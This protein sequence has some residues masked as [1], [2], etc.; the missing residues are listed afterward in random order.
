MLDNYKIELPPAP[1][2]DPF[3]VRLRRKIVSSVR[4]AP[5]LDSATGWPAMPYPTVE[6]V[7]WRPGTGVN[8]G[9]ELSRTT[10]ELMLARRGMTVFDELPKTRR[11]LAIG[12]VM[13]YANDHSV[14]W[15]SGVNGSV[16][17]SAHTYKTLDVRAVRGPISRKF[18]MARGIDVPE[19]YGD[20]GLLVKMLTGYRF[21]GVK[22]KKVGLIPHMSDL[23]KPEVQRLGQSSEVTVIDP[24]QSWNKVIQ[25]IAQSEVV[26][27]SSLHGLIVADAFGI[28]STYVRLGEREGLLKY[29][30]YY[31]GTGRSLH[32]VTSL[33]EAL[34]QQP[35]PVAE[36]D[37]Q[38]LIDAFPYDIWQE[39]SV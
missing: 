18:L 33:D 8:F 39:A 12:S 4:G 14:I 25:A 37:P 3:S 23:H 17:E 30:D 15:G 10:V 20:P 35:R 38:P 32:F 24:H 26:I 36:F 2:R 27:S 1:I 34:K 19:V 13:H 6:L 7:Y 9:D 11:M 16:V 21:T 31:A 22:T 5:P 28:P 29:E